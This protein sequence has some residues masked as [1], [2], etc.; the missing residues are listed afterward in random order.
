[1][2]Q[3]Y[4]THNLGIWLLLTK[5]FTGHFTQGKGCSSFERSGV[6]PK[7]LTMGYES[8]ALHAVSKL[9]LSFYRIRYY[10]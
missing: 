10:Q 9:N 3:S 6:L 2:K 1:M 4:Y 7:N 5:R 8:L